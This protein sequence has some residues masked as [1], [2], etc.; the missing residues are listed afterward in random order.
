[1]TLNVYMRVIVGNRNDRK[2]QCH[3]AVFQNRLDDQSAR[4]GR[5]SLTLCGRIWIKDILGAQLEIASVV[6][7]K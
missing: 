1:M 4:A 5:R 2:E 3:R 6:P 7:L